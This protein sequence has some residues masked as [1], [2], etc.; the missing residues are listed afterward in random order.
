MKI[1]KVF[2]VVIALFLSNN[3]SAASVAFF[4]DRSIFE[5]KLASSTLIDFEGIVG[6]SGSIFGSELV[7]DDVTFIADGYSGSR[8]ELMLSGKNVFGSSAIPMESALIIANYSY[9]IIID[10]TTAGS[11]YTAVG[12]FFGDISDPLDPLRIDIY[13]TTGLLDSRELM[14]A[15]M[16]ENTPSNF[17]GWIVEGDEIVSLS[18]ELYGNY[19]GIDDFVYG[20][21]T[22]PIPAAF[23]LFGSGIISFIGFSRRRV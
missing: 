7:V 8:N 20:V 3:L 21:A 14:S 6:D 5:S 10:L 4:T 11:G 15:S 12:G 13:G 22:V 17:F 9:P 18:Y 2:S 16:K 23:W 19:E 1:F